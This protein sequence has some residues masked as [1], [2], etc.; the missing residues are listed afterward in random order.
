MLVAS[1]GV[2]SAA[3]ASEMV[4]PDP[5]HESARPDALR[6]DGPWRF[7]PGRRPGS[8]RL[9]VRTVP[10]EGTIEVRLP[11]HWGTEQPVVSGTYETT[12]SV[13]PDWCGVAPDW[14][15]DGSRLV[16]DLG[17]S[18]ILENSTR[19]AA[20]YRVLLAPPV[21][22]IAV[23][24]VGGREVGVI[25]DAPAS[26]RPHRRPARRG[27]HRCGWRCTARPRR[28]WPSIR[29]PRGS[30]PRAAAC[31]AGGST[32]RIST[33]CWTRWIRG[34]MRFP[35]CIVCPR[36]SRRQLTR[37]ASNW[38]DHD[39]A[40]AA[41]W[42]TAASPSPGGAERRNYECPLQKYQIVTVSPCG[43]SHNVVRV[44]HRAQSLDRGEQ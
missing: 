22:E 12:V 33:S 21:R 39:Q 42:R 15:G 18:R 1:G 40:E 8:G 20:S 34:C 32:S 23:I 5:E 2:V 14:C 3:V 10:R 44:S 41:G 4:V 19:Q 17:P 28:A 25:W 38:A 24:S 43:S 30:S 6:L 27:E 13:D 26:A 37:Q 11:H 35:C 7:T 29:R 9:P 16:L 36:G 31:T